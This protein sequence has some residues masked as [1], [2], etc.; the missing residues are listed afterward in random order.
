MSEFESAVRAAVVVPAD[1]LHPDWDDVLRRAGVRRGMRSSAPRAA[2]VT[3]LAAIAVVLTVPAFGIGERLKDLVSGTKR[4]GLMFG[5]TLSRADGSNA[6]TFSLRTSRLFVATDKHKRPLPHPFSPTGVSFPR[7]FEVRWRLDLTG[8]NRATSVRIVRTGA[9]TGGR[10][11][12]VACDPCAGRMSG[13][14]WLSR[15][16]FS[17]VV[18]GRTSATVVTGRGRAS[19]PIRFEPPPRH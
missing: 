4:P 3:G 13:T 7:A 14:L 18:G 12:A 17:L 9:G 5:A 8:S 11:V 16:A 6:G 15:G 1:H 19:G 10:V 2:L